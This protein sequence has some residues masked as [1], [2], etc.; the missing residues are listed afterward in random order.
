MAVTRWPQ[1]LQSAGV[2]AG[3]KGGD[4]LDLGFL[5]ADGPAVWAGVFTTNAAAAACVAWCRARLGGT[6][7]GVVVNSGN[8]NACT[9]SSGRAAVEATAAAGAIALGCSAD[10]ILVCS[11]GPIGIP[12]DARVIAAG[13]PVAM[14]SL[15]PDASAFSRSIMTTD[16]YPKVSSATAGGALVTG[17]AK[18]AAMIAPNMA[19]MLAFV[20]T[21]AR[22]PADE[23]QASLGWAVERTFNRLSL[24]A[25]ESTNDSVV[26]L[27]TG[28]GPEVDANALR[29]GLLEVCAGLATKI[30]RDAEGATKLV[31]VRVK[32]ARD[33]EHAVALGR[34]VAASD[35]WRAAV[36]GG[37]PNWGRVLAAVGS[38][39]RNLDLGAVS[40]SVGGE[41]LFERG[42]PAGVLAAAAA[43]MRDGEFSVEVM[44]GQGHG[45]A[46]VLTA[47]LSEEY[48]TL[49][50]EVTT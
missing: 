2:A 25:C 30:A 21:D 16:T 19:T 38:A 35:L 5:V 37:D 49:N 42:E 43:A 13:L 47:D 10:E 18:G 48:V 40:V 11:T 1:G 4:A 28:A 45:S 17:V 15:S 50:A 26:A 46:E 9:G 24:D 44:L 14:A 22:V 8:A 6:V 31:R 33:E 23:L 39:D 12:L 3:I 27:A 34:A 32:G 7:R 41:L 36:H 29:A 20:G